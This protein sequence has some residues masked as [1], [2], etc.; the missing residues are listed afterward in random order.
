MTQN[1]SLHPNHDIANHFQLYNVVPTKYSQNSYLA[2]STKLR[3]RKN[4]VVYSTTNIED[5]EPLYY[6][7]LTETNA[8]RRPKRIQMS[9]EETA[10][11]HQLSVST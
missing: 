7:F 9:E 6:V 4:K 2:K 8:G 10:V 3:D 5:F 1:T 11:E